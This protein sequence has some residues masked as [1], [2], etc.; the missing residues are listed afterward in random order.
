MPPP[1]NYTAQSA[2]AVM[3]QVIDTNIEL[4]QNLDVGLDRR[5]ATISAYNV[6]T[7][8]FRAPIQVDAGG[9][10]SGL[11]PDGGPLPQGN[12][13][14]YLQFII[15]PVSHDVAIASTDL[16]NRISEDSGAGDQRV[17]ITDVVARL[18]AKAKT[19]MAHFRNCLLQGY[20]QGILATVDAS[21][22]AV[23]P[24]PLTM[25]SFGNRLL[26]LNN[27]YQVTDANLNVIGQVTVLAKSKPTGA[28]VDTVTLDNLPAALA[29]GCFF[30]P[31]NYASGAPVG[32]AGL[33]Y[34]ITATQ[35]GDMFGVQRTVEQTQA[36]SADA[37]T[38][39]LSLGVIDALEVRKSLSNGVDDEMEASFYYAN[40][41]QRV[42][43]NQLGFAKRAELNSPGQTTETF[44]ISPNRRRPWMIGGKEV[45]EDSVAAVDYLYDV[46]P[47][48][49]GKARYPASQKFMTGP[50]KGF[51]YQRMVNGQHTTTYDAHFQDSW[52]VYTRKPWKHA[53]AHNLG[54]NAAL[55]VA[56]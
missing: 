53:V 7:E 4:S 14:E 1:V 49:L 22:A 27:V 51:W 3:R 18:I 9:Q 32:P 11:A 41:V 6:G 37:G 33:Q 8:K 46:C 34:I 52:T 19:K 23:N 35:A 44:D 42:T 13:A 20:N 55:T 21:Y 54:L 39:P 12:G 30:I 43:A 28:T 45:Q 24:V 26:D 38:A 31:I 5:I 25:L 29:E 56:A 40:P 17:I 36:A 50:I 15:V 10:V 16:M 2:I 48:L 47:G